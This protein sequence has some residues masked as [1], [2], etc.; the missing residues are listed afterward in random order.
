M[1]ICIQAG[2]VGVTSGATGAPGEQKWN[3]KIVPLVADKLVQAGQ[4]VYITDALA[5][6]DP[7][8]TSTDWDLFLAVHYDADIYNDRG[9]F[10]DYPDKDADKV[11]ERSKYLSDKI[12]EVFFNKTGIPV[13]NERSN[14]NTKRYY[15]WS[16][17]TANTP[18]VLIECGVGNRKPEDYDTLQKTD[19]IVSSLTKA[20]LQALGLED[21]KDIKIASLE[22]ELD[23]IRA[24]RN[25]WRTRYKQL[26]KE[27]EKDMQE[28]TIHRDLLQKDLSEAN[29]RIETLKQAVL[30]NKTPLS[31]Y[32]IKERFISIL[33]S[34]VHGGDIS[35]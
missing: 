8:V 33:D 35:A 4:E 22:K 2:H 16:A 13:H 28:L 3:A 30:T 9:G 20:I 11:W 32:T 15:M 23:E 31:A 21:E 34:I 1:K 24:S 10:S 17:L 5:N 14:A 7:K 27:Y 19:L 6:K 26:E 25:D 18:C 29:A 12:E